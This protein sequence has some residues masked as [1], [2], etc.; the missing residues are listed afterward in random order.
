MWVL[1]NVPV[2]TYFSE[3]PLAVCWEGKA[4]QRLVLSVTVH[5]NLNVKLLTPAAMVDNLAE[6][7]DK[8]SLKQGR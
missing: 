7:I 2:S 8:R 4:K 6:K 1:P 3:L 5:A